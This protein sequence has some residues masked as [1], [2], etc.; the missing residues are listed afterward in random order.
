M[1]E[2]KDLWELVRQKISDSEPKDEIKMPKLMA[3]ERFIEEE[4]DEAND[5]SF[6]FRTE[7]LDV[8]P[9]K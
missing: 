6:Q 2:E 1:S 5:T 8:I 7:I 9:G 3:K 4:T